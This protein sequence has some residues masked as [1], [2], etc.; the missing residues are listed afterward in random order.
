MISFDLTE[1]QR[2]IR[3]TVVA[4]ARDEIRPAAREADETGI[5]PL[6]LIEQAWELGL[7]RGVIPEQFGGYGDSRSAVT[8]AI[9]A[10]EL[11]FGDLSIAVHA[12][13]PRLIA[14]PVIEFG[15]D[16]QRTRILKDFAS[17]T[18]T[19]GSAALIE[20][21]FDFDP[22]ALTTTAIQDGASFLLNGAKC[23][24]PLAAESRNILVFATT[25]RDAE[26]A[27]VQGFLIPSTTTGLT[28]G[29]RE[30]N[31]GLKGLA[32]YEVKLENCRVGQESRLGREQGIDF[33]RIVSQGRVAMA[34]MAV[35]VARAAYE[36]AKDYAKERK[37][38]GVPIA[39]KQ[40]IAF[41]LAEMAIE[42]DATR[43]LAWEAA[44]RL[45]SGDDALKESSQA[46]NYAAQSALMV[47]DNAVQILGGHGYIRE[48]PV[49][50]FLRNA[51]SF[52]V[53]E[54][55]AIV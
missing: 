6:P 37:A 38:F 55:I 54:G 50:M 25:N 20:P 26:F 43:L 1:E 39:T 12:L 21:R 35:G 11:A 31:M 29:G 14:F 42:I 41:M 48:H 40:A 27:G 3:D 16:E 52:A 9:V 44:A 47:T 17:D 36:Y 8:G 45:D 24:A 33:A 51:R 4:F 18:F 32:S 46:R 22:S 49:E 15:T 30:H 5:I 23:Y 7:V 28:I 34:A 13:A 19:A 10:E 2:M 53:I